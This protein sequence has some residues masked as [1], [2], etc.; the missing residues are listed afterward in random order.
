MTGVAT[1]KIDRCFKGALNGP[2]LVAA[3]KYRLS[4]GW[5]GGA[6]IFTPELGEFLLLF[7]NRKGELYELADQNQGALP[8]SARTSTTTASSDSILN[9][10]DDFKAGLEDSDP[11]M[12]LKSI[13][14][15][16]HLER[17][18][19]TTE[20]RLLLDQGDDV[21][22]MY[23]F[24]SL[25][26]VG[27]LSVIPDAADYLDRN[28]P[29]W[30]PLFLPRDRLLEMRSR[31][32][33]ALCDVRNPAVISYLEHFTESG[34][35]NIRLRALMGLR[36][37]GNPRSAPIFLS[38]RALWR[39]RHRLDSGIRTILGEPRYLRLKVSFMVEKRR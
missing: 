2:I 34:N 25:L 5:G 30:K 38:D 26:E 32:F 11:E 23:V 10:E 39:R 8:V 37:I 1:V 18:R 14:W 3:D 6:H 28:P 24:E 19:S 16:G 27:D 15:L 33:F 17:L 36:A 4:G 13:C 7:L 20:L 29:V 31:V 22:R 21:E 35:P 12:V 9:L